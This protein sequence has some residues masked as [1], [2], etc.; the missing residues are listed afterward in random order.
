MIDDPTDPLFAAARHL[1]ALRPDAYRALVCA[2]GAG[3][4]KARDLLLR[5]AQL[6]ATAT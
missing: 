3:S 2:A 1:L 6:L 4:A 5:P